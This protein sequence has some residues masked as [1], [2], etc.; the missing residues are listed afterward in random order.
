MLPAGLLPQ[1]HRVEFFNDGIN[2]DI[3]YALSAGMVH[4]VSQA[5]IR[6]TQMV[7]VD[8]A[9]H[10][11]KVQTLFMMGFTEQGALMEKYCSCLSGAFDRD[12]DAEHGLLNHGEFWPCPSRN[13][14]PGFGI[15]CNALTL[16]NG[17]LTIRQIEVLTLVGQCKLDKEISDMLNISMETV[18]VHLKAIRQKA[19]LDNKMELG[20]LARHKNLINV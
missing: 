11:V 17:V 12:A 9:A 16:A 18:K 10:P 20:R 4:R 5:P 15:V 8:M 2:I 6:I 19:G 14:C 13:N 3:S 7:I 1:D